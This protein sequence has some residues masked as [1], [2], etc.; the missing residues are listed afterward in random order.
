MFAPAVAVA[1]VTIIAAELGYSPPLGLYVGRATVGGVGVGVAVAVAVA[2]IEGV[3]ILNPDWFVSLQFN[4]SCQD[5]LP[6]PFLLPPFPASSFSVNCS[7]FPHLPLILRQL[8]TPSG[9][10][11]VVAPS[12]VLGVGNGETCR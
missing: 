11:P 1:M 7:K 3:S 12:S 4:S 2:V 8:L 6:D 9:R 5:T 10:A